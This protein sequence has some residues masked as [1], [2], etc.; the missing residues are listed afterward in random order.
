MRICQNRLFIQVYFPFLIFIVIPILL[1]NSAAF[2]LLQGIRERDYR[3]N[4]SQTEAVGGLLSAT[5]QASVSLSR[6][7]TID[8]DL[9][10]LAYLEVQKDTADYAQLRAVDAVF[11]K[12]TAAKGEDYSLHI[13][14]N[15][16]AILLST[17]GSCSDFSYFYKKSYQFGDY[18][19]D[20]LKRIADAADYAPQFYPH[21]SFLING[22]SYDGFFYTSALNKPVSSRQSKGL[23]LSVIRQELTDRLFRPLLQNGGF[24]YLT[25]RSGRLLNVSGTADC[26]IRTYLPTDASGYLPG[27]IYGSRYMVSYVCLPEGINLYA[28]KPASTIVANTRLLLFM[29]LGLDA[30]CI[31]ICTLAVIPIAKRRMRKLQKAFSMLDL[32][33]EEQNRDY[34]DRLN[35]GIAALLDKNHQL[36]A[37]LSHD[38]FL[39]RYEFWNKLLRGSF[40]GETELYQL[41]ASSDIDLESDYFGLLLLAVKREGGSLCFFCR[42]TL[43]RGACSPLPGRIDRSYRVFD[44]AAWICL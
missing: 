23:I 38:I 26:E 35:Q 3:E 42:G 13:F 22:I 10:K 34:Y 29:V 37:N 5:L 6:K 19:L 8:N 24:C 9:Q 30:A 33:H 11:Q 4:L 43:G 17:D 18:S 7:L 40:S 32:S 44:G 2:Q 31:V 25:D 1:L 27:D 16:N 20:D 28:V 14:Y 15:G 21:Q 12:Y 39:L 36:S 41:A